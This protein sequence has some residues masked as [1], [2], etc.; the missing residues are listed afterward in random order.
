MSLTRKPTLLMLAFVAFLFAAPTANAD[1]ITFDEPGITPGTTLTTQYQFRGVVFDTDGPN[2]VRVVGGNG[3][4]NS[5]GIRNSDGNIIIRFT[6][7]AGN[8][9]TADDVSFRVFDI[10]TNNPLVFDVEAIT[11]GGNSTQRFQYSTTDNSQLVTFSLQG[12]RRIIFLEGNAT[13]LDNLRFTSN[14]NLATPVPE[15]T[16][17][18]L[19]G[20]GLVGISAKLRR[21][22]TARN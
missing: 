21:R 22:R 13:V 16:T 3:A 19:L 4:G 1:T 6:N 20:S 17:M 10:N 8:A 9:S 15:P 12:I 18:L 11:P 2:T 14:A 7:A 5:N